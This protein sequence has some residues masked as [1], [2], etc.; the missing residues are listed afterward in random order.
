MAKTIPFPGSRKKAVPF[1]T[2]ALADMLPRF[3]ERKDRALARRLTVQNQI[4]KGELISRDDVKRLLGRISA[5]WR[6]SVLEHSY[7]SVPL[8]MAVLG[9]T[10]PGADARLRLSFDDGVYLA[11]GRVNRAM[12]QWLR[13]QEAGGG[14]G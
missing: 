12:E 10:V 8:V 3:R 1:E 5:A 14:A 6:G 9:I 11:G 13:S 7:T 2:E 4:T